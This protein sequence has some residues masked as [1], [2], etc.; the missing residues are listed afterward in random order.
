MIGVILGRIFFRSLT[1]EVNNQNGPNTGRGGTIPQPRDWEYLLL[2]GHLVGC[3][4]VVSD[5]PILDSLV[6]EVKAVTNGHRMHFTASDKD[7]HSIVWSKYFD[8]LPLRR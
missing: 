7:I 6:L 1:D 4:K 3:S 8:S 2:G 5:D